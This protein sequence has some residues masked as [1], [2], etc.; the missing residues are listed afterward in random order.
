MTANPYSLDLTDP[1]NALR[2]NHTRI[3]TALREKERQQILEYFRIR[4]VPQIGSFTLYVYEV[5][6]LQLF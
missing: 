3:G 4:G 2:L 1:K 5:L 6:I